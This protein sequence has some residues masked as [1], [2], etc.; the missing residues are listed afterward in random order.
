M[1]RKNLCLHHRTTT[2]QHLP[3]KY[4]YKLLSFQKLII[5]KRR[6]HGY[7]LLQIGNADQTVVW[8]DAPDNV[9]VEVEGKNSIR[10][11]TMGVKRQRCTVML[12]ITADKG[13]LPPYVVFMGK[14]VPTER[15]P[16]RIFVRAQD[17]GWMT[18]ELIRDWL[19]R[20]WEKWPGTNLD[21]RPLLVM[22]SFRVHLTK[23]MR[24]QLGACEIDLAVILGSMTGMLQQ[25]EISVN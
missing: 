6:E 25:L 21:T 23:S 2:C 14:C 20:M 10:V 13:K 17:K 15:F 1:R 3:E 19:M 8:F 7:L 9:T 24:Q 18:N 16:D 4:G 12:C 5:K 22:N 11:L